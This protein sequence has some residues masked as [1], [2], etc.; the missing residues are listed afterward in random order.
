ANSLGLRRVLNRTLIED[1]PHAGEG[2]VFIKPSLMKRRKPRL[3]ALPLSVDKNRTGSLNARA[4]GMPIVIYSI[5]ASLFGL[6]IGSFLNVVIHRVPDGLSVVRPRS[7]CPHCGNG[8]RPFDNIPLLSY[9]LLRG[10]CRDCKTR[11]SVVYPLVELLT[12]FVFV[13]LIA[14]YGLVWETLLYVAFACAVIALIFIDAK[15]QLLPNVITY[16]L[17]IFAIGA[18]I[19]RAV[20]GGEAANTLDFSILL[21]PEQLEFSPRRAALTGGLLLAMAA[22]GFR[23][24]DWL[25]G[26]LFGRYF[27]WEDLD[28]EADAAEIGREKALER[29]SNRVIYASLLAGLALAALWVAL[30][31]NSSGGRLPLFEAA[32]DGLLR[33]SWGAFV[34][35][36]VIWLL[37]TLYFFIRGVEGMGLGD[38]K[39]MA[40]A[41][42]FLGWQGA[43]VVLLIGSILGAVVGL[44]MAF[45]GKDGL[46]TA[47]PFGVC[48]GIAALFV[49]LN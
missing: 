47:L 34:G 36:G 44:L 6:A 16:P 14:K 40:G 3:F 30:V 21:S 7:R 5:F 4:M 29:N 31:F 19:L 1:R 49:M 48:L 28:E 24:F 42:A 45:R 22:I 39:M 8:I 18:T 43:F 35:G 20:W 2:F 13:A 38:V 15:H 11:I 37:R 25:D 26:V 23:F 32:Y 17:F 27:E 46:K 9:A 41:G 10:R 12:A 33:A